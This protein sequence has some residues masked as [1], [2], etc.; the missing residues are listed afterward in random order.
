MFNQIQ[1]QKVYHPE[2]V[3]HE[4]VSE[5]HHSEEDDLIAL[6]NTN[7]LGSIMFVKKAAEMIAEQTGQ[8]DLDETLKVKFVPENP[9]IESQSAPTS[10][11]RK[12]QPKDTYIKRTIKQLSKGE[13]TSS[14][15]MKS[16]ILYRKNKE[17]LA[18][19]LPSSLYE[20]V[21]NEFHE[22]TI[23][24]HF[25]FKSTV[26]RIRQIFWFPQMEE[27]I[28]SK[29]S[30]CEVCAKYKHKTVNHSRTRPMPIPSQPLERLIYTRA[31]PSC[32]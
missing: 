8:P 6:K 17:G 30:N 21:F 26:N 13:L 12:E 1:H 18:I 9:S 10:I 4:V 24:G 23:G 32:I 29:I 7:T 28:K 14:F 20:K 31:A 11:L 2:W 15:V 16:G 3:D 5:I 27:W 19:V 25:G 22:E